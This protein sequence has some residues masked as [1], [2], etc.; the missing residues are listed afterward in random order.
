MI[1]FFFNFIGDVNHEPKYPPSFWHCRNILEINVPRTNNAIEGW[2]NVFNSTFHTSRFSFPLLIEKLK[3][4]E[5][6]I[7]I[8]KIRFDLGH[9]L[10]QD[11]R[12]IEQEETLKSYLRENEGKYYGIDFVFGMVGLIFY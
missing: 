2:H 12:Y 3:D 5:D 7:R 11:K 9:K 1:I 4:E 8:K 10:E 6:V